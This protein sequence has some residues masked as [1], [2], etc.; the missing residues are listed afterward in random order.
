MIS[1]G[2]VFVLFGPLASKPAAGL[3][4]AH[5]YYVYLELPTPAFFPATLF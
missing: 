2:Y 4:M 5:V 3:A 1:G